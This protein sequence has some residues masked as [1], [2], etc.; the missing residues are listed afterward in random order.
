ML[1]AGPNSFLDIYVSCA[2]H[3]QLP[4]ADVFD[5]GVHLGL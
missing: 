2:M 5:R 4:P 3:Y 1:K